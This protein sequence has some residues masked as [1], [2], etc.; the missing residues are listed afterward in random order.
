MDRLRSLVFSIVFLT[1]TAMAIA[2]GFGFAL[3]GQRALSRYVTAWTRFHAL[4]A[5]LILG[6]HTR[7]E[8]RLPEGPALIAAK[9]ESMYETL[10]LVRILPFPAVVVKREL[11]DFP[12]WR[13][14]TALYGLVPV[15]REASAKALRAMLKAAERLNTEHRSLV[16]FPEG[17]RV[18]PGE[19]PP[20]QAGF[21]GLYRAMGMPVVPVAIDSG[22]L[23][24]RKGPKHRGI[25]T[26]RFGAPIPPGLPRAE[27]ERRVH[28]AINAL[29]H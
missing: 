20:L 10:E 6:I 9:H 2:I 15:D 14:V 27:I 13:W 28:E 7:I 18:R 24:P 3:A 5:R 16:I 22:R 26:F 12:G 1:G 11:T 21:A 8:G 23:W 19:E 4:C 29:H 17:T 25:V